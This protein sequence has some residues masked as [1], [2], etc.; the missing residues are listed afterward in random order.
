MAA[1]LEAGAELGREE[2]EEGSGGCD[3]GIVEILSRQL[4]LRY[5]LELKERFLWVLRPQEGGMR[6]HRRMR[7]VEG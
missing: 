5:M 3:E 7:R 1:A 2:D 4:L 6:H